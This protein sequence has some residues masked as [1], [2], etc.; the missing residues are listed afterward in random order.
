MRGKAQKQTRRHSAVAAL[1]RR[2]A[3]EGRAALLAHANV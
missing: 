1:M 2:C 3:A